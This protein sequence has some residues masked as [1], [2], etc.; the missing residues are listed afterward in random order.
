MRLLLAWWC[1]GR[2]P[3]DRFPS[4]HSNGQRW[5]AC[6]AAAAGQRWPELTEP[7]RRSTPQRPAATYSALFGAQMATEDPW[8][9]SGGGESLREEGTFSRTE[10]R[11]ELVHQSCLRPLSAP[12]CPRTAAD[13]CK[14]RRRT[15][16]TEVHAFKIKAAL[17]WN[18][19]SNKTPRKY[20]STKDIDAFL[21][22][23]M[24]Y[25]LKPKADVPRKIS[26]NE[27]RTPSVTFTPLK[28]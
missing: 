4:S 13:S 26:K 15:P 21:G 5:R 8:G 24:I 9:L 16:E 17:S 20:F 25:F 12:G 23:R 14:S 18:A 10:A 3:S 19:A 1:R 11:E 27:A 22:D 28:R 6:G 2:K 7:S